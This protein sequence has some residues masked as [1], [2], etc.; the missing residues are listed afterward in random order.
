MGLPS[1]RH[2]QNRGIFFISSDP[3][4]ALVGEAWVP[5]IYTDKGWATADGANL[6]TGIEEWRDGKKDDG[7]SK[8]SG[9]GNV[10]VQSQNTQK[11]QV[12]PRQRAKSQ[13]PETGTV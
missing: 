5:A 11:R 13:K 1:L 2:F 3:V 8:E 12:R 4:E 9:Q 6:L 10:G 7:S